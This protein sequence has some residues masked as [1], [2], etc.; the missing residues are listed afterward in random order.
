MHVMQESMPHHSAVTSS[1][2]EFVNTACMTG[3][4]AATEPPASG[5][6]GARHS[7]CMH[8]PAQFDSSPPVKASR[9]DRQPQ[10]M[11]A[12]ENACGVA[13]KSSDSSALAPPEPRDPALHTCAHPD[14]SFNA[15]SLEGELECMYMADDLVSRLRQLQVSAA[16]VLGGGQEGGLV[17]EDDQLLGYKN[18][19]QHWAHGKSIPEDQSR[20]VEGAAACTVLEDATKPDAS[21]AGAEPCPAFQ[22]ATTSD[23]RTA[24]GVACTAAFQQKDEVVAPVACD[25][26][27]GARPCSGCGDTPFGV[28]NAS[29]TCSENG[30]RVGAASTAE[31][32]TQTQEGEQGYAAVC[33]CMGYHACIPCMLRSRGRTQR[34]LGESGEVAMGVQGALQRV[35]DVHTSDELMHF[36]L[37]G[38]FW[39][40]TEVRYTSFSPSTCFSLSCFVPL[41]LATGQYGKPHR[42]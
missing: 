11:A 32:A 25:E 42:G 20:P 13:A 5:A 37:L 2:V 1:L 24:S 27:S 3:M 30:S 28:N 26:R 17:T 38:P 16:A 14:G 41:G 21:A 10:S 34:L 29:N 8:T 22:D 31:C 36:E 33:S 19:Q 4:G 39:E 7:A 23:G 35:R 18:N 12:P 40:L 6:A 15:C 9:R